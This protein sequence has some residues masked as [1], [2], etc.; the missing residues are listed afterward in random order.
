MPTVLNKTNLKI[1]NKEG[2]GQNASF[3]CWGATLFVLNATNCLEWT[4]D[5]EME[6]FLETKTFPIYEYQLKEGD[7]LVLYGDEYF[8][9]NQLSHTAVYIGNGE[10]WHK[11]GELEAETIRLEEILD[12]YYDYDRI[13]YRRIKI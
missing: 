6:Y 11:K 8:G 12:I 4:N 13:E 1:A 3:N 9:E 7:I 10:Y 5:Y 2:K